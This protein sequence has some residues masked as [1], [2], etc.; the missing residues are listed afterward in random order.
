MSV[1][2]EPASAP[3]RG[4]RRRGNAADDFRLMADCAPVMIWVSGPDRKCV[5]VNRPWLEFTGRTLE[6]AVGHGW[7][8]GIHPE[9]RDRVGG[10]YDRA[11]T[12]IEPFELEYRMRRHDGRYR[13]LLDKGVPVVV[14]G[15]LS[16]FI[17][18]CLDITD[19]MLAEK[20]ARK[21]EED[22]KTLAERIPDV[23]VRLDRTKRCAYANPAAM[24]AFGLAPGELIGKPLDE[25][26]LPQPIASV[27]LGAAEEAFARGEE[28]SFR[29]QGGAEPARRHFDGRLIPERDSEGNIDAVLAIAYDVTARELED[30]KRAELLE[31]ERMARAAA[32]SATLARDQFLAIVSHEL[33]SPL[34]GIKSWTHVLQSQLRDADPTVLRA[35]NGIMIGVEHQVRLIEDL[36]DVTRAMSGNLGLAKQ[37]MALLPVLAESVES[38]RA[39]ALEKGLRIV[40]DYGIGEREIHGDAD[41]VRQ[42]FVNLLTNAIKFTP[43]GGAIRVSA[44]TEGAMARVEFS[45]TGAGIPPE[46]LPYLFDPFRQADQGASR[47]SQEGLG[48]GLALVQRLAELHGG[49]ATCESAGVNRGSTFRV[50]LPLLSGTGRRVAVERAGVAPASSLPSL[51]GIRVLLIDDQREA[52]ESLA[53]LLTQAGAGVTAAASC[54]EALAHLAVGEEHEQPQ[55]IV[56]DIAMPG[57]DGYATLKRIR[58]WEASR[59]GTRDKRPAV[60]LSAH[61][62]REDRMRALAEG[63]QMHLTKPVAPAELVI[64]LSSVVRGMRI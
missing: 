23:I 7:G 9:D 60:A 2:A 1:R 49:Y 63:F 6:E 33:R 35:L 30:E 54:Q 27:L 61:A 59:G 17:G 13:W 31:H 19:R 40:T 51:A 55:V 28:Q 20:A 43:A 47:R 14:D 32:E 26:A 39:S 10:V 53:T 15:E 8:E 42:I 50:Y 37:A 48:L 11:F 12:A 52:R 57:E 21:R 18:S 36:L 16:G 46:F 22:F 64:V 56:C 4:L 62:Q 41:R 45:D 34:N 38:L 44:G 58:A 29:F 5:Y 24:Q 3:R 25:T